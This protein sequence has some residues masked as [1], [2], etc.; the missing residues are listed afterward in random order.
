MNRSI[1]SF[2]GCLTISVLAP[3]FVATLPAQSQSSNSNN[4]QNPYNLPLITVPGQNNIPVTIPNYGALTFDM[5]GAIPTSGGFNITQFLPPGQA[6]QLP[7][8]PSRF[9]TAGQSISSVLML[10]DIAGFGVQQ[11]SLDQVFS[12][13]GISSGQLGLADIGFVQFQTIGS[14]VQAIPSLSNLQISQA[15]ALQAL[16]NQNQI[17]YLNQAGGLLSTYGQLVQN[18]QIANLSLSSLQNLNQFGLNGIP[19]LSNTQIQSFTNW[20]QTTISQIPGLSSIPLGR[21]PN[22]SQSFG[23]SIPYYFGLV[24]VAFGKDEG[25]Q[26]DWPIQQSYKAAL[27]PRRYAVTGTI[28][29]AIPCGEDSCSYLELTD[30]LL[31]PDISPLHGQEWVSGQSQKVSGGSGFCAAVGGGQEP[32]GRHPFGSSF[33]VVLEDVTENKGE[34]VLALYFRIDCGW[35]G[36]T[37]YILGPIPFWTVK[38][39]DWIILGQSPNI[40]IPVTRYIP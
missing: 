4:I 10:G 23:A 12:L 5:L 22:G 25:K 16:L 38:E 7:Y 20:G 27:G 19:G 14:L 17:A 39:G 8:D 26:T 29:K 18:P 3:F 37:P 36:Q 6:Q 24:D 30:P 31:P 34:G 11:L 1:L 15:P 21:M 33:K 2:L 40:E 35:L 9:W 32:T 28:S 13:A